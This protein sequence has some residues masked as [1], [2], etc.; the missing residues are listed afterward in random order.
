MVAGVFL[1]HAKL[2]RKIMTS[3]IGREKKFEIWADAYAIGQSGGYATYRGT[4]AEMP[5]CEVKPLLESI[6]SDCNVAMR[7]GPNGWQEASIPCCTRP[8]SCVHSTLFFP[9]ESAKNTHIE[10]YVEK[11]KDIAA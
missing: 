10:A 11:R 4:V 1:T 8:G 5:N 3:G 6:P 2:G 9:S 7:H